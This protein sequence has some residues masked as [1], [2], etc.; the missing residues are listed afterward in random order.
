MLENYRTGG[1]IDEKIEAIIT[2]VVEDAVAEKADRILVE[3]AEAAIAKEIEK[4]KKAL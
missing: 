3:V 4:I 2:K 1:V